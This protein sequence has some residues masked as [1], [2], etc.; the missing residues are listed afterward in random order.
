MTKGLASFL[1]PVLTMAALLYRG[2]AAVDVN[3]ADPA[4]LL[5]IGAAL[6]IGVLLGLVAALGGDRLRILAFSLTTVIFVDMTVRPDRVF[7]A[8][9][10]WATA[11]RDAQRVANLHRIKDALDRYTETVGALPEPALYG[12]ATGPNAFWP[13]WWDVSAVDGDG[14]GEPFLDFLAEHGIRVPL[15]PINRTTDPVDP[16]AGSQFVYFVVPA[17]YQ[18]QGGA[19]AAW[20]HKW[21]YV[22]AI[23]DL[24]TEAS[25]PPQEAQGSG[26]DCL[27]RDAPNFFAQH[28]DYVLC[29]SFV[30]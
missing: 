9:D 20:S 27:W 6:S 3:V 13:G 4:A 19:C 30:R 10:R 17:G 18:Y 15:D 16:R 25:R 1:V 21:V 8:F 28:F 24:E 5:V 11:R 12:E 23:T 14:D 7:D 2:L 29:G 22:L 26:C